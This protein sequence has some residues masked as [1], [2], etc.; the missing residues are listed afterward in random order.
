MP[1][2]PEYWV[3][4]KGQ[5]YRDADVKINVWCNNKNRIRNECIKGS[6]KA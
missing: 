4:K 1:Y 2:G 6:L 3:V 5:V